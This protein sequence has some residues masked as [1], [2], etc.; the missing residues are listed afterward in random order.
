MKRLIE[1]L[2]L[3]LIILF[4]I[5]LFIPK[6]RVE[7]V[8]YLSGGKEVE[9][10]S[11]NQSFSKLANIA[12]NTLNTLSKPCKCT[13]V[14]ALSIINGEDFEGRA[15]VIQWKGYISRKKELIYN[16]ANQDKVLI[17]ENNNVSYYEM[18]H[19]RWLQLNKWVE[20]GK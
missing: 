17:V 4:L 19:E 1:Q 7:S 13:D 16:L 6:G 8:S 20:N 12:M 10:P 11:S 18:N 9:I 2:P 5:F 14:E 3:L 15:V